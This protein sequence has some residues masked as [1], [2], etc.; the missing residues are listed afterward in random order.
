M[1]FDT[2][3]TM[4][5]FNRPELT[6]RL[7]RIIAAQ[8]PKTLL[9]IADGPRE[10]RLGEAEKCAAVR[11]VISKIDWPCELLTNFSETNLG[12]RRRVSSGL[13]WVFKQVDRSIILEDDCLPEPSFFQFAGKCWI[14]IATIPG[15]CTSRQIIFN[16]LDGRLHTAIIFRNMLQSGVGRR[17]G[18]RGIC[19][20]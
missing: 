4:V 3:I 7:F 17:G 8:R 15:S 10:S 9:I 5:I 18:G 12:C 19:T 13:D 2:P 1:H 14:V 11:S 6:E 20:M 16:R